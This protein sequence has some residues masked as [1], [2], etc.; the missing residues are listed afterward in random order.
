MKIRKITGGQLGLSMKLLMVAL[1]LNVSL[2]SA[3]ELP[4]SFADLV[5]KMG[6]AVVNV[7][8]TKVVKGHPSLQLPFGKDGQPQEMPDFFKKF[9]DMPEQEQ[10][11][12]EED[13]KAQSLGSG[14]IISADGYIVT[15]NHVVDDS[16]EI[17]VRCTNHEEYDAKIIGR[18][19]K[20]DVA[21]IKITPKNGLTFVGFGNSDTLRVGD[22]VIAVGN[23]FGLEN[24]V[25]A[26]IVSGTGRSLGENPYENF[27]QTDASINMGNSG[28]PLFNSKGE[29]VGINT[30]IY[31]RSG[32]SIGLGFAIPVNMVKNVVDQLKESGKVTRGWLG[33]M[34]QHV[35]AD[36]AKEFG[37]DR[38]YGALVGEVMKGSPADE[39]GIKQGDV[40]IAF[41]GKVINQMSDLPA[42]VAQTKV[43]VK[44]DLTVL[45]KGVKQTITVKIGKLDEDQTAGGEG[46]SQVNEKLGLTLQEL[47]P[48]LAK[49][50]NI[51]EEK[52]LIV[53]DVAPG[54]AAAI[55][56]IKRGAIILEINQKPV[57]K[58]AEFAE[59]L[60]KTK[61]G[62]N[63]LLLIKEGDH[64]RFVVLKNKVK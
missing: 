19:P 4:G 45:R 58:L 14:V 3:A 52:G 25:T 30:A 11:A 44:A 36:L 46:K 21:L 54:S 7:Y 34:I 24:T 62:D 12:P 8:T 49:T 35:T 42:M 10:K 51:K 60:K 31:S 2:A 1:L 57:Q 33:V 9:F 38:P 55:N 26:G 13:M 47:T 61:D 39:A 56:G 40:I 64:T 37:L 22:W 48:E 50:M 6:P 17:R 20:T 18:D 59:I 63:L 53:S 28:G 27:I 5:E 43:G 16:E 41:M 15:N 32:G 29:L 23:P